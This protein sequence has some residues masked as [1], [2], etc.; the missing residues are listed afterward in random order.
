M[1]LEEARRDHYRRLAKVHGYKSRAAY[2]LLEIDNSFHILKRGMKVIDLGSYPGGWLQVASGKV[3][4]NG[5]VIGVDIRRVEYKADNVICIESSIED[6]SLLTKL[7]GILRGKA[8]VILSDVSPN[9]SGIWSLDHARQIHLSRRVI[10]I[11]EDMLKKD[12]SAVLKVFDGDMFKE[13]L[14]DVKKRFS[15]VHIHKPNASRKESSELY[16]ICIGHRINDHSIYE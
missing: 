2:K 4:N 1:R 3:G 11:A 9:L 13:F 6:E 8:D 14:N 10:T 5:L 16:L 15:R 12:G 7:D